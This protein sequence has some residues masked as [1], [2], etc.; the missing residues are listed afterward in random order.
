M[1][2]EPSPFHSIIQLIEDEN[3]PLSFGKS[4]SQGQPYVCAFQFKGVNIWDKPIHLKTVVF[5]STMGPSA[6]TQ[7]LNGE[8]PVQ[9]GDSF[10]L[11]AALDQIEGS[12]M[13]RGLYFDEFRKRFGSFSIAIFLKDGSSGAWLANIDDVEKFLAAGEKAMVVK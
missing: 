8:K 2:D 1:T 9:A 13:E 7:D 11:V 6:I 3:S 4:G 10:T 12:A 5:R